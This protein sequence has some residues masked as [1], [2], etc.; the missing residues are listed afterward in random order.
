MCSLAPA[1]SLAQEAAPKQAEAPSAASFDVSGFWHSFTA[2]SMNWLWVVLAAVACYAL[3]VLVV[4]GLA[5]AKESPANAG[6]MGCFIT[7]FLF[8]LFLSVGV[9]G[10]LTPWVLPA[11]AFWSVFAVLGILALIFLFTKAQALKVPLFLLIAL[12]LGGSYFAYSY[13][14]NSSV[15]ADTHPEQ[16]PKP[17]NS[18]SNV[19]KQDLAKPVDDAMR[20][21]SAVLF[22][23]SS[24]GT[25]TGFFV[26]AD[27]SAITC[28]HVV[29]DDSDVSVILWDG[30]HITAHVERKSSS[31][32]ALLKLPVTDVPFLGLADKSEVKQGAETTIWGYKL[33]MNGGTAAGIPEPSLN[34]GSIA[35][36][37]SWKSGVNI[38]EYS[39]PTAHGDSGGPLLVTKSGKVAGVVQSKMD[40][41]VKTEGSKIRAET[42]EGMA[43]A[44]SADEITKLIAEK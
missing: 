31:D 12:A 7:L 8:V 14:M 21:K 41:E 4:K 40:A 28:A 20:A 13:K 2:N 38:I 27:G 39:N 30:R 29:G 23:Q 42:A 5:G 18:A 17:G 36:L 1:A 25:G 44:I 15:A 32:L 9:L 35:A 11:V 3:G 19:T 26:S 10:Y 6:A 37:R 16:L 24:S 22:I 34:K 33:G 43:F